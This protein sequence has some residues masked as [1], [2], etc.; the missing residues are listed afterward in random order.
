VGHCSR[1]LPFL[2]LRAGPSPCVSIRT[3]AVAAA[4]HGSSLP[5][6][7]PLRNHLTRS[8]VREP[9]ERTGEADRWPSGADHGGLPRTRSRFVSA[10]PSEA[11]VSTRHHYQG[12]YLS[13]TLITLIPQGEWGFSYSGT[14]NDI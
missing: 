3:P 1:A 5:L 12:R 2:P 8:L 6:T 10:R 14:P 4:G 7:A 9:W 11:P 13:S